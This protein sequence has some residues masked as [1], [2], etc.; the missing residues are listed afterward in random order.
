MSAG[1]TLIWM[2]GLL[3]YLVVLQHMMCDFAGQKEDSWLR[4]ARA[5]FERRWSE[6]EERLRRTFTERFA[7]EPP[8]PAA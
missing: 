4:I 6:R 1:A 5:K 7:E 3:C 2:V 8:A